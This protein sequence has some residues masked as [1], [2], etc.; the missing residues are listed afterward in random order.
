MNGAWKEFEESR[1]SS[2]GALVAVGAVTALAFVAFVH[3]YGD[4]HRPASVPPVEGGAST[5]GQEAVGSGPKIEI[6]SVTE[7]APPVP[8]ERAVADGARQ[9]AVNVYECMVNGQRVLSD[10]PCGPEARARTV[11]VDQP[12]P[13]EVL[14]Q[15]QRTWAAQQGA[16]PRADGPRVRSA[17]ASSAPARAAASADSVAANDGICRAIDEAIANLNARMRQGYTSQEGEYYRKRWHELQK[18]RADYDCGKRA[19]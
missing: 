10:Q 3:F 12:D 15:Q 2:A 16:G 13:Q 18:Q 4:E 9:S 19:E 17:P 14:R 1:R 11:V 6:E 7:V 5:P 8:V